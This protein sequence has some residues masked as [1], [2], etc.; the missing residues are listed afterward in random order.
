MFAQ[1][2]DTS[3]GLLFSTT[4]LKLERTS[5]HTD[6]QSAELAGDTGHNRC[7]ARAGAAALTSGDKDHVGIAQ[8]LTD[9]FLVSRCCRFAN[10]GIS[11]SA[12]PAGGLPA[13]LKFD[14]SIR[15]Q[16]VLCIG[17]NRDELDPAQI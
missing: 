9:I 16:Q 6:G 14:I 4:S 2:F 12:Q 5:N 13:N 11:S 3:I 10:F 1:R 17:V 15:H 7:R 8:R